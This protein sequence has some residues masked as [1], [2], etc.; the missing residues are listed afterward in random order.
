MFLKS[1]W[2]RT[3]NRPLKDPLLESYT[4]YELLY[5][6]NDK[7]ERVNAANMAFEAEADK[8]E[9][10]QEQEVFDW[11]EEEERKD[12]EAA[13]AA[14]AQQKEDDELW[15]LEQLKKEHGDDFGEDLDVDFSG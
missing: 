3:Y 15:M 14:L 7:K 12:R 1:W 6:F 4:L 13:E 5:E 2:S 8:I 9:V 11:I 10:E